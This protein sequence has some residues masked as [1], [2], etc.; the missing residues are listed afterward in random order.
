MKSAKQKIT[1]DAEKEKA[2]V[3]K[4]DSAKKRSIALVEKGRA[5]EEKKAV[6]ARGKQDAAA[7]KIVK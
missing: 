3:V 1:D 2:R 6:T 5:R 4:L 7:Q